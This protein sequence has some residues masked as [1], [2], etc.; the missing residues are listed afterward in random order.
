MEYYKESKSHKFASA[1]AD[2]LK[3][4]IVEFARG[5]E[6]GKDKN[7]EKLRQTFRLSYNFNHKDIVNEDG[8]ASVNKKKLNKF[9]SQTKMKLDEIDMSEQYGRGPIKN[10]NGKELNDDEKIQKEKT[11]FNQNK[12]VDLYYLNDNNYKDDVPFDL[13]NMVSLAK[14]ID[15]KTKLDLEGVKD[16]T[17]EVVRTRYDEEN[18]METVD[19][20][21]KKHL[22]K[23]IVE[24]DG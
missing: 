16:I 22:P 7:Y 20:L 19:D 11:T 24:V 1:Q 4:K 3:T 18:Q 12:N 2:Q 9:L 13:Y 21:A 6:M 5:L 14:R 10:K 17:K 15:F 23:E 8:E